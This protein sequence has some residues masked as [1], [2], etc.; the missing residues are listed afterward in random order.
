VADGSLEEA[1][2]THRTSAS[3]EPKRS[4]GFQA[5]SRSRLAKN[6]ALAGERQDLAPLPA[7][8]LFFF[9]ERRSGLG[10]LSILRE[11]AMDALTIAAASGLRARMESL[12]MLANNL[13]NADTSGYKTDREFYNLY[14]SADAETAEGSPATLPVIEKPWTDFSQGLLRP[15]GSPLDLALSGKGFFAVDGPS[16]SLYTRNGNFRVSPAGR[17]VTAEG[18]PVRAVGG[19][20]LQVQPAL[21]VEVSPDGTVNQGGQSLG[22]IEIADFSDPG[23]MTK[24]GASYFRSA[25][26]LQP[27]A[28]VE[29][30]Q[31][32]LESSNVGPAESAVRLVSVMRQFEMLQKAVTLGGQMNQSAVEIARVAT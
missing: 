20:K 2:I 5:D 10:M 31:G 26:A 3:G 7:D 11:S 30:S 25:I 19:A 21:A 24:Q 6:L 9:Y 22:Q 14:T 28:G 29:V 17:L 12:D 18:Y 1:A 23:S 16:G 15:T 32:K 13:A 4:A 8:K 27:A